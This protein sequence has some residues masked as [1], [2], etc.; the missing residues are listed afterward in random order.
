MSLDYGTKPWNK[1]AYNLRLTV[2]TNI[3][4]RIRL[5]SVTVV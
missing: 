3:L 1:L 4:L 5:P 2:L